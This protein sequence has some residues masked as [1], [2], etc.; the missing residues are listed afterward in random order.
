M[1]APTSINLVAETSFLIPNSLLASKKASIFASICFF[2]SS[3]DNLGDE[4]AFVDFFT[5]LIPF[6]TRAFLAAAFTAVFFSL[7]TLVVGV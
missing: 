4:F 7:T 6:L 2:T 5:T 1:L 3:G